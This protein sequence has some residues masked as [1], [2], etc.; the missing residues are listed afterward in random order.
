MNILICY[1]SICILLRH[2]KGT[3]ENYKLLFIRLFHLIKIKYTGIF[4]IKYGLVGNRWIY[5]VW[6]YLRTL[7]LRTD[8]VVSLPLSKSIALIER[9]NLEERTSIEGIFLLRLC[10]EEKDN[11]SR[12][13][14]VDF[15]SFRFGFIFFAASTCDIPWIRPVLI[16]VAAS[17]LLL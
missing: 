1:N 8:G 3:T 10:F 13:M 5:R 9:D 15:F 12:H 11:L 4:H 16:L 6:L 14:L 2:K 7:I 17:R